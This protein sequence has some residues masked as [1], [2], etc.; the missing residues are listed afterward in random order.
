MPTAPFLKV[1]QH[2]KILIIG[3]SVLGEKNSSKY[4]PPTVGEAAAASGLRKNA[5]A[6]SN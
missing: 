4:V 1:G 2:P 6:L 3:K 5:L